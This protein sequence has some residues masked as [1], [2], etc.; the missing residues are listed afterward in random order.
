[1]CLV[2]LSD[3]K[4]Y[5]NGIEERK[6]K[7]II[8]GISKS[9]GSSSVQIDAQHLQKNP[10]CGKVPKKQTNP[11][12]TSRISNAEETNMHYP[13]VISVRRQNYY[14]IDAM[15]NP[16]RCSGSIITQSTA[17]TAGHCICR[18]FDYSGHWQTCNGG[19]SSDDDP[20]NEISSINKIWVGIG[21]KDITQQ[22]TVDILVAF[23][24]GS[25]LKSQQFGFREDIGLLFSTDEDGHGEFFYQDIPTDGNIN[26]GSV[27]LAAEKKET[28]HMYEGKVVTVGWGRRYADTKS[29]D[30]KPIYNEHSCATNEF[31]PIASR[32]QQCDINDIT[33]DPNDWGCKKFHKPIGYDPVKCRKYL[34]QAEI[35]IE[36]KI[37]ELGGSNMLNT[38]WSLTNIIKVKESLPWKKTHICYKEKLFNDHGWC[39]ILDNRNT[40]NHKNWGFCSSSCELMNDQDTKPDIYHKMIWEFPF[41]QPSRSRVEKEPYYIAISSFLPQTSVFE[42]NR[43]GKD[44]LKFSDAYKE[45]MKDALNLKNFYS[46]GFQLPCKGDSGSGHWMTDSRHEQRALVAVTSHGDESYC[47]SAGH[48]ILTSH[49]SVLQWIKRHSRI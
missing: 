49:P 24:M 45:K 29:S 42:F 41:K 14:D 21:S 47:G 15:T 33:S 31:G 26:V 6:L 2:T 5:T 11:P 18:S 37:D 39:Y 44:K 36:K 1:M 35:A 8:E 23:V 17:V 46:I 19:R 9:D 13:W 7:K 12:V 43:D 48:A 32:L 38:L 22:R 34:E 16:K 40:E 3:F 28:P 4:W 10:E 20:V 25:E 30:G 27:C